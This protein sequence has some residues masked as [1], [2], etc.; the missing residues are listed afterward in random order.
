MRRGVGF[1][2]DWCAVKDDN[3]G[4]IHHG[5][6]HGAYAIASRQ[7]NFSLSIMQII[8]RP[9]KG[10]LRSARDEAGRVASV[11]LFTV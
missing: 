5:Y 6:T 3:T 11:G 4:N 2:V 10:G 9:K 8:N 1:W 7:G